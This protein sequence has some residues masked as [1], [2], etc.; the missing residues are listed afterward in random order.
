MRHKRR[1]YYDKKKKK[2]SNQPQRQRI[3]DYRIFVGAFL[4]GELETAVQTIREKYDLKT[5]KICPPHVTIAGTYWRTGKPT[6]KNEK[7][8][9]A[10]LETWLPKLNVFELDL[11]TI[12]T[13]GNRVVFLDV[14]MSEALQDA[15]RT[16]QNVMGQDKH[17]RFT[18]HCT[19]A[20]RLEPDAVQTMVDELRETEW[21]NGRF[22]QA[23][24]ELQL[25][26]R[27]E[28]DPTWRPILTTSLAE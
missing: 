6:A 17:R 8:L 2:R 20:M 27:G 26:Q 4:T 12:R 15:R 14:K 13:F 10:Q 28:N 11:G 21:H 5:A 1:S 18:P 25:M 16:L 19:L 22:T 24:T 7:E 3:G 23:V 9:I